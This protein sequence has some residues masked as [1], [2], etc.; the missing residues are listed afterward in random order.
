MSQ[1]EEEVMK[2]R[3]LVV[4][5]ILLLMSSAALPAQNTLSGANDDACWQ[6]LSALHACQLAQQE[7]EMD[8][9][10]RCTSY[11]EYQCLP[12]GEQNA[13]HA[14]AAGIARKAKSGRADATQ[15]PAS[16][17]NGFVAI[18]AGSHGAN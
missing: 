2:I 5:G 13:K 6:S 11:P 18:S 4:T 1:F 12:A 16:A 10:Q 17:Q 14:E 7:R 3:M 9:A 15:N 8:Y